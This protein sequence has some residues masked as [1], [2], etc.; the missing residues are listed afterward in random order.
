MKSLI[1]WNLAANPWT[2]SAEP[3]RGGHV[4]QRKLHY[5]GDIKRA[6]DAGED[7]PDWREYKTAPIPLNVETIEC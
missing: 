7:W 2:S 5:Y 4:V 6:I 1:C 3:Q